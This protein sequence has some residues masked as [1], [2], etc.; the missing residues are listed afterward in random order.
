MVLRSVS[1]ARPTVNCLLSKSKEVAV[2]QTPLTL[3]EQLCLCEGGRVKIVRERYIMCSF[4]VLHSCSYLL[5]DAKQSGMCTHT[6]AH[7]AF[8]MG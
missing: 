4:L 8:N 3:M 5:T 6:I 2:R 7:I 1:G